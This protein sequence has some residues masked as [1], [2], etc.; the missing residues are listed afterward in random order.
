MQNRSAAC[1]MCSSPSAFTEGQRPSRSAASAGE[2]TLGTELRQSTQLLLSRASSTAASS[3]SMSEGAT[4]AVCRGMPSG[5][6][7]SRCARAFVTPS[8]DTVSY[9]CNARNAWGL[10]VHQVRDWVPKKTTK[11]FVHGCRNGISEESKELAALLDCH[12]ARSTTHSKTAKDRMWAHSPNIAVL[13]V[14]ADD[15]FLLA[16]QVDG[17]HPGCG[18]TAELPLDGSLCSQ[19]LHD[20]RHHLCCWAG[21]PQLQ[22][23]LEA[24][25][26][27]R[28]AAAAQGPPQLHTAAEHHTDT[29]MN[30]MLSWSQGAKVPSCMFLCMPPDNARTKHCSGTAPVRHVADLSSF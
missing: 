8:F 9:L 6:S 18:T 10:V 1:W 19:L 16:A 11:A 5:K 14:E 28:H 15:G 7:P 22:A 17:R 26:L 23:F 21:A 2:R 3:C 27:H 20:G 4:K 12:V 30:S 29:R 13:L 24:R 25:N